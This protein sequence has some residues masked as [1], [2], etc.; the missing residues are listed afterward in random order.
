[1][2]N[3]II[4]SYFG[5][6]MNP[7]FREPEL[8]EVEPYEDKPVRCGDVIYFTSPDK[9]TPVVHRV[10]QI[11]PEGI[12]TRGDNNPLLD[13]YCLSSD[14]ITG[15]VVSALRGEMKH[16]VWGGKAGRLIGSGMYGL[17]WLDRK[18][19]THL[20]PLYTWLSQQDHFARILPAGLRPRIL[21]FKQ[22]GADHIFL[23]WG[24]FQIGQYD[25]KKGE[26]MIQRPFRLFVSP[27]I[28]TKV[29]DRC[30]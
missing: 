8:L 16:K 1:M 6:S 30:D 22:N 21:C 10:I 20:H 29:I 12:L 13:S 7:T 23:F 25:E 26:W 24:N 27:Q 18:I 3:C 28:L 17:R 2:S 4:I 15:K 5:K 14:Q 19:S 11:T 9:R